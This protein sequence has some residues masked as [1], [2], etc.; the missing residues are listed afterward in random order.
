MWTCSPPRRSKLSISLKDYS[1]SIPQ[2]AS[3][4]TWLWT[5]PTSNPSGDGDDGRDGSSGGSDDDD[6]DGRDDSSG[7]GDDDGDDDGND[8]ILG[9]NEN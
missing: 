1:S 2:V 5:T 3:Q 9:Y 7:D 6:G 8:Q 4:L